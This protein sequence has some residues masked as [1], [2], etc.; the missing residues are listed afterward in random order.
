LWGYKIK[1]DLR[2]KVWTGIATVYGLDDRGVGVRVT[3]G[4]RI[5]STSSRP[6]RGPIQ[7]PIQWVPVVL[8]PGVKLRG[9]WNWLLTTNSIFM[10]PVAYNWL[11]LLKVLRL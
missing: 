1:L 7:P 6:A 11:Q 4:S 9:E 2:I 10:Q 5:F 3:V 8:S